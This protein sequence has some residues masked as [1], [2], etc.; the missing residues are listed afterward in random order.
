MRDPSTRESATA[1]LL[2]VA[3]DR[4]ARAPLV[5]QLYLQISDL[6]LAG[7]ITAGARMP[8]TRKLSKD[9]QISRTVTLDVFD[10][11]TLE[12]FLE[13]RPGS[14]HYVQALG[15]FPSG[16]AARAAPS[17]PFVTPRP[18]P[19]PSARPF[20]PAWPAVDLFP[21]RVWGRMLAR[22]WRVH[23]DAA[24]DL[25]WSGVPALREALADHLRALK[26]LGIGSD[27]I[28]VT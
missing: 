20:D 1:A 12:G 7:R 21:A 17:E 9:L 3:L 28:L 11:L 22:G 10:Q 24:A 15:P 16:S 4:T 26:G 27:Q 2:T 14:G 19:R 6:I 23:E 5:R 8:S 13:S 25:S 18:E